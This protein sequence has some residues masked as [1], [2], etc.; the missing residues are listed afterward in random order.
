MAAAAKHYGMFLCV[1]DLT[2]IGGSF[3]QSASLAAHIP[4]I[5]AVEG[6]GRQYCPVGN[7]AWEELYRPMFRIMGG[8]V[9]T[10]LLTG[11]G[12]GFRWPKNLLPKGYESMAN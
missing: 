4:T 7:E 10:E 11:E 1:Q 12:L 3:M 2:C 6:N 5:T 8:V 9:P